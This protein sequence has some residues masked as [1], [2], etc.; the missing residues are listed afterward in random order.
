MITVLEFL[1]S[2]KIMI[3]PQYWRY[4]HLWRTIINL[5]LRKLSHQWIWH[6]SLWHIHLYLYCSHNIYMDCHQTN[7]PTPASIRTIIPISL[8][9]LQILRNFLYYCLF[10]MK[11]FIFF[12]LVQ[13]WRSMVCWKAHFKAKSMVP[14]KRSQT[15]F[16]ALDE[17]LNFWLFGSIFG[18]NP[19]FPFYTDSYAKCLNYSI[20]C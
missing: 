11:N 2:R 9:C 10:G 4:L 17:M 14:A 18:S 8:F 5:V 1:S 3:A 15:G 12:N 6:Q 20:D 16:G 13:F 7:M 19:F